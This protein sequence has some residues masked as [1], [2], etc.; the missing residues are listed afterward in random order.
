MTFMQ[1][2]NNSNRKGLQKTVPQKVSDM[3]TPP[4]GAGHSGT[5]IEGHLYDVGPDVVS[6]CFCCGQLCVPLVSLCT[7]LLQP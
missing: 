6:Q 4:G 2:C 1:K 7:S 3:R 5:E